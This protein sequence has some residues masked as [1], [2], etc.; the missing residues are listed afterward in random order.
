MEPKRKSGLNTPEAIQKANKQSN[1]TRM[2]SLAITQVC[3]RI[4]FSVDN[5]SVL[6]LRTEFLVI[7]E[8]LTAICF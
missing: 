8:V 7:E 3:L 6:L 1:N 2:D 4:A 5:F